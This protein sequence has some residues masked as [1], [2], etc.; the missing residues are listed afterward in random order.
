M[1]FLMEMVQQMLPRRH[2]RRWSTVDEKASWT[3]AD[4][5]ARSTFC[6]G[7]ILW[8]AP[9]PLPLQ[10]EA[11]GQ[12]GRT[13][14]GRRANM[15]VGG[16]A[17][18]AAGRIH[19]TVGGEEPSPAGSRVIPLELSGVHAEH[20]YFPFDPSHPPGPVRFIQAQDL[21]TRQRRSSQER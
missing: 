21:Q 16:D 10:R 5:T 9:H 14:G 11:V 3:L 17:R 15:A 6:L 12:A 19:T 20:R 18:W 13:G 7:Q 2:F 1:L 8:V 4:C